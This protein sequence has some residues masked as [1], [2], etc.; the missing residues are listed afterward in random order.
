MHIISLDIYLSTYIQSPQGIC[1]VA[2]VQR[3]GFVIH[4]YHIID[5][6]I[7]YYLGPWTITEFIATVMHFVPANGTHQSAFSSNLAPCSAKLFYI[8]SACYL[9]WSLANV[10]SP[11]NPPLR[12]SRVSK[13]SLSTIG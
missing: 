9:Q 2:A 5:S 7:T 12:K 10:S 6:Y 1:Y 13:K 3:W 11:E 8:A 4:Q